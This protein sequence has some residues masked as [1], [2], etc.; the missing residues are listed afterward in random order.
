MNPCRGG[1]QMKLS[2]SHV[3]SWGLGGWTGQ[4]KSG[5]SVYP[6]SL[7]MTRLPRQGQK[8]LCSFEAVSLQTVWARNSFFLLL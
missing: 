6:R 2:P 5:P 7:Y 3:S 1:D 4:A 8:Q